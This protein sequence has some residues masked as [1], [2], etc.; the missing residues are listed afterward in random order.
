MINIK[1][2]TPQLILPSEIFAGEAAACNVRLINSKRRI[3]SFLIRVECNQGQAVMLPLV[4]SGSLAEES[5]MLQFP[6]RGR[7][8]IATITISSPFPVNFFTRYWIFNIDSDVVVFPRLQPGKHSGDGAEVIPAGTS[9]HHE[10]GHDGELE[11]ITG[12]SG[13]EPL[14]VIHWKL[15]ARSDDLQVKAFGRQSAFPLVIE[16]DRLPGNSQEDRISRAAW[17]IRRW[18]GQRPV[19]LS[20]GG[21][22]FAARTGQRH[23]TRLLTELALYGLD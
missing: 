5:V 8:R 14:R 3:P 6:H 18:V 15:S 16:L 10:R 2:L 4:P 11:G 1:G 9:L 12:Y 19:G 23:G 7:A 17:L 20:L 21:R 22:S 13:R